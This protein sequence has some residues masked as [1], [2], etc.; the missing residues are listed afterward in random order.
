VFK[1]VIVAQ[2]I[3]MGNGYAYIDRAGNG[4]PRE[5]IPLLPGTCHPV[6]LKG[7]LSYAVDVGGGQ[8]KNVS[9]WDIFHIKGPGLDGLC[10]IA[11][12][13]KAKAASA[14]GWRR[15]RMRQSGSGTAPS[16]GR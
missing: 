14:P 13:K 5:L 2:A 3:L 8:W 4:A 7:T 6:R 9:Y 12:T 10:G 15:S 11:L 16:R 1:S